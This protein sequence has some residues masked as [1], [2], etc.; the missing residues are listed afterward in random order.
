MSQ[1]YLNFCVTGTLLHCKLLLQDSVGIVK[2]TKC[3]SRSPTLSSGACTS[4]CGKLLLAC[5]SFCKPKWNHSLDGT[6]LSVFYFP[7]KEIFFLTTIFT[8]HLITTNHSTCFNAIKNHQTK[9]WFWQYFSA[10][11]A[12]LGLLSSSWERQMVSGKG[13]FELEQ[14][15]TEIWF[16]PILP[17]QN[18]KS[19]E[20]EGWVT[21]SFPSGRYSNCLR[22]HL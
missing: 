2:E 10:A 22:E 15:K 21:A 20:R 11:C 16:F 7:L 8:R 9:P 4:Y 17:R 13:Y 6:E 18:S 14:C 5:I 19:G 12:T 1:S 3:P